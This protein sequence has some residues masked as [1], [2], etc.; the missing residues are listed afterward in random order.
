MIFHVALTGNAFFYKNMVRGKV[1]ELIPIDPGSVTIT[2]NNDY[3][4]TYRVSGLDGRTMDFPQSLIWHIKGPSWDTW[5]G[6]DAVQQARRGNR[7]HDR[8]GKHA[9]RDARQRAAD[10]RRIFYRAE[11]LGPEKYIEIQKWIAA[12]LGGANKHKPFVIDLWS[13]LDASVDDGRRCPA[14]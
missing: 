4:L 14:P 6:L 5:R 8:Y 11:R 1:K 7:P 10:F 9:G 13:Q 2:R 12:Q 3:S